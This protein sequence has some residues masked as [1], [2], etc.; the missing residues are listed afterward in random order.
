MPRADQEEQRP[1]AGPLAHAEQQPDAECNLGPFKNACNSK[2]QPELVKAN[3]KNT[4]AGGLG[5]E[6]REEHEV[7]V[8]LPQILLLLLLHI[9][10]L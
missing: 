1:Q 5:L 3:K 4:A 7:H 2:I 9:V 6:G 10:C 8:G